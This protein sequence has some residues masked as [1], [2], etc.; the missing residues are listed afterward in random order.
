MHAFRPPDCTNGGLGVCNS[1]VL[2]QYGCHSLTEKEMT[3][4][5]P[6]AW[7][8]VFLRLYVSLI[9]RCHFETAIT[10]IRGTSKTHAS[11]SKVNTL[12]AKDKPAW[13][14]FPQEQAPRF[15]H[16]WLKISGLPKYSHY[17]WVN[18]SGR[19]HRKSSARKVTYPSTSPALS[20]FT[21]EFPWDLS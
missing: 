15:P 7:N 3:Q 5:L 13:K 17:N 14:W 4:M 6:P 8:L 21:S 2:H 9:S 1:V 19:L 10:R 16:G 12:N 11:F 20:G 18:H